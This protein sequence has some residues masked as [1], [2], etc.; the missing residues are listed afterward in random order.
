[1]PPG[2][3]FGLLWGGVALAL[4]LLSPFATRFA[5]SMPACP[6]KAVSGLPCP[7]CGTTRVGLAL[8]H[9]DI[10]TAATLNPLATLGWIALVGGGL[11]AGLW[12]LR[13]GIVPDRVPPLSLKV[14][15]AI[16]AVILVNWAYLVVAG[17]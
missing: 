11:A 16:G 8:A 15:L 17:T 4:V 2:R 14:R 13:G 6:L 10:G 3:Q 12:A 7:G 5:T 9:F 1:M